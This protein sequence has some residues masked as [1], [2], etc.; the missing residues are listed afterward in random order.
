MCDWIG[1]EYL[2]KPRRNISGR[3]IIL[4]C[5]YGLVVTETEKIK[6]TIFIFDN[7]MLYF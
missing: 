7:F 6:V 1:T 3:Y 4:G 2:R 5:V